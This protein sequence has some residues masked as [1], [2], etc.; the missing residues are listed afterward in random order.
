MCQAALL[1]PFRRV[2]ELVIERAKLHIAVTVVTEIRVYVVRRVV[3]AHVRDVGLPQRLA[4]GDQLV[5]G[6]LGAPV[7]RLEYVERLVP[8]VRLSDVRDALVI[9]T[10]RQ[11]ANRRGDVSR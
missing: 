4:L 6:A 5:V 7:A 11:L 1:A 9:D 8:I 2:A 3:L 10:L